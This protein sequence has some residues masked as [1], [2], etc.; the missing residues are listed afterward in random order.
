MKD[1]FELVC[2][3]VTS[4]IHSKVPDFS[5]QECISWTWKGNEESIKESDFI[6]GE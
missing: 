2:F 6:I 3:L 5:H 4:L 1:L